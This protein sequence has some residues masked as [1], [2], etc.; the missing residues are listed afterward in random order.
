MTREKWQE[1]L[2]ATRFQRSRPDPRTGM[3]TVWERMRD[4]ELRYV[5][6]EP[7]EAQPASAISPR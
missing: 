1:Y 3:V 2:E 6:V 5:G 4:G 7:A